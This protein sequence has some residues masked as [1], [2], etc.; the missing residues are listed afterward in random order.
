MNKQE[1]IDKL[2]K[3]IYKL[4]EDRAKLITKDLKMENQ[5]FGYQNGLLYVIDQL[6]NTVKNF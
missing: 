1:F 3:Q 2:Q 5:L 6:K 4:S